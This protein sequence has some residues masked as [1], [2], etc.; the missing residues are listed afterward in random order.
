[1]PN[2]SYYKSMFSRHFFWGL[3]IE[4][5][6][7]LSNW[8]EIWSKAGAGPDFRVSDPK[9]YILGINWLNNWIDRYFFNKVSDFLLSISLCMIVFTIFF[10]KNIKFNKLKKDH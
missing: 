9:Q 3:K 5:V 10:W 1:M 7:Y 2:I 4:T 6:Q 8:Y